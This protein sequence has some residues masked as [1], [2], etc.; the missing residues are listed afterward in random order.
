MA[1]NLKTSVSGRSLG[2]A[3]ATPPTLRRVRMLVV[4]DD[5]IF[6][7]RLQKALSARGIETFAAGNA[8]DAQRLARENKP[9]WSLVD[10]RMPGMG[11]LELVRALRS[12]DDEMQIVVLTGYG[13]I[14][15]A[16]EAVRAGATDYLTKPVDT[17][18]I[19][20]AFEKGNNADAEE[21][22]IALDAQTPSLARVEW[23]YIH[24]VLSDCG[25]NISQ[26]ARKLGIHRRSLQRKL[27]KLPPLE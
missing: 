15:T 22:V 9:Q 8:A 24:R 1:G 13:T 5:E 2:S 27:Q 18:Q 6:R 19:L 20:G 21:P 12:L 25:G 7:T 3:A 23:D 11:G 16:V 26:A 10:L 17:D 4:D 14:A